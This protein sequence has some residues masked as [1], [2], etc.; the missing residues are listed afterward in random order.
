M[1]YVQCRNMMAVEAQ[2]GLCGPLT[3]SCSVG[4][5]VVANVTFKNVRSIQKYLY[6]E[7]FQFNM[8][9]LSK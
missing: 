5:N 6:E 3:F 7:R 8:S 2:I 1:V 4:N 9:F